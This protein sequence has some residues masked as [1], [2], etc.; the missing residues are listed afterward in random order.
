[1]LPFPEESQITMREDFYCAA[2]F[3]VVIL[4]GFEL[5]PGG[6]REYCLERDQRGPG[7]R[8]GIVR[9][10]CTIGTQADNCSLEAFSSISVLAPGDFPKV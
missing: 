8:S 5:C 6:S 3:N 10:Q 4:I 1:M 7:E 2:S 9:C